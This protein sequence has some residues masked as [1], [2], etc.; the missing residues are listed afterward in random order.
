MK[1]LSIILVALLALLI[2]A[3]DEGSPVSIGGSK[4]KIESGEKVE[5]GSQSAGKNGGIL[6]FSKPGDQLDGLTINVADSSYNESRNFEV[7]YTTIKSHTFGEHFNPI[8]P[9][10]TINN[11][12]GYAD[13]LMTVEVPVTIPKGS[14]AMGFLYNEVT[15]ELEGMPLLA[16]KEKSVVVGTRH[17]ATSSIT[18][19]SQKIS[20]KNRDKLQGDIAIG[21]LIISA[22]SIEKL[23]SQTDI[24]SDF[25]PGYDDWEFENKGSFLYPPGLCSGM[26]L[27][28]MWYYI[29]EEP[30]GTSKL[31]HKYD[32]YPIANYAN[33]WQD[34]PLGIK[35]SSMVQI[36]YKNHDKT[37]E[38][39]INAI[40]RD[41]TKDS[42]SWYAFAYT[43][44]QTKQPQYIGLMSSS[45][46]G[47]VL[48]A[49]E[50]WMQD[51]KLWISDPNRPG[52]RN[53]NILYTNNE[54]ET[55]Q[56]ALNADEIPKDFEYIAFYGKTAVVDWDMVTQR[57]GELNDGT[58]G[59]DI[60]PDFNPWTY[61]PKGI[62]KGVEVT[63]EFKTVMDT[64]YLELKDNAAYDY[65]FAIFDQEGYSI[66]PV[67]KNPDDDPWVYR[68]K[69]I[70]KP[71]LNIIG[72]CLAKKTV[73]KSEDYWNWANF[74]WIDVYC[75]RLKITP[76]TI[77]KAELNKDYTWEAKYDGP[78]VNPIYEWDF[79]DGKTLTGGKNATHNYGPAAAGLYTITCK[80]YSEINSKNTLVDSAK[81]FIMFFGNCYFEIDGVSF[82]L[83]S[84]VAGTYIINSG[85]TS[86]SSQDAQT[87]YTWALWL[88]GN[89][90]GTFPWI[91]DGG[92][93]SSL[94]V[95][96]NSMVYIG[97]PG[98]STKI[99]N[100]GPTLGQIEGEFS[101]PVMRNNLNTGKQDTVYLT[102]GWFSA[103]NAGPQ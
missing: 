52:N 64:L 23:K 67:I 29:N 72:Y 97:L 56:A 51:G 6:T 22:I 49:N 24:V 46:G 70:L 90:S 65:A 89:T 99:T 30:V 31:F 61:D 83:T 11:G 25:E 20:I 36:D 95:Q 1:K 80:L 94:N 43:I 98:G 58:I 101:G 35:L 19:K 39:A 82:N 68:G 28:A 13:R 57:W 78:L 59:K 96:G 93:F 76:D 42:L 63:D 41:K 33:F 53:L 44:L 79:G 48:I 4:N 21:N 86:I 8:S 77:K 60:F 45:G 14:F 73:I 102:N 92:G 81:A 62:N 9:M 100:Y 87:G 85:M 12:G 74:K 50:V 75:Q 47:H 10:I 37:Y 7:S 84:F 66:L 18:G 15:G 55:Y 71:G 27:T 5:L 16:I 26:S 38:R 2:S 91:V 17:F 69:I 32:K 54:F 34:N 103:F 88:P 3:C 40:A